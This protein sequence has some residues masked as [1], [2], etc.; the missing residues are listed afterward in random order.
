[1]LG[2]LLP[3][4]AEPDAAETLRLGLVGTK[5]AG[6]FT[7]SPVRAAWVRL[8]SWR[9][10]GYARL[11]GIILL[12]EGAIWRRFT[13]VPEA[14]VQSVGLTQGPFYRL[15]RLAHLHIHTVNGPIRAELGAVDRDVALAFFSD[16]SVSVTHSVGTDATHRWRSG[17]A[18]A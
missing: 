13:V 2:L 10:N 12:R 9:R 7:T 11:P 1:V 6:G 5:N 8:L 3:G 4:L 14:R 17:E 18:S 16:V 15:L